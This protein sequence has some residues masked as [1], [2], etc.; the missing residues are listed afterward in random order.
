MES[1]Q[2]LALKYLLESQQ[3]GSLA[4]LHR[5]APAVSMV[6]YVLLPQGRG[7]VLHVSRL[8]AHTADIDRDYAGQRARFTGLAEQVRARHILIKYE[9]TDSDEVKAAARARASGVSTIM[10]A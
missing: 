6:P 2:S 10:A 5:G 3:V 7:F 9:E 4:T 1:S 8:A